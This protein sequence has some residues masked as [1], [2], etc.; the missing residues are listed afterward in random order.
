MATTFLFLLKTFTGIVYNAHLFCTCNTCHF[1]HSC[2]TQYCRTYQD[3]KLFS[4]SA[5]NHEKHQH[6]EHIMGDN[7]QH[8]KL[9]VVLMRYIDITLLDVW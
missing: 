6:I 7:V 1:H 3:A 5:R 4:G 9:V 2:T 8:R